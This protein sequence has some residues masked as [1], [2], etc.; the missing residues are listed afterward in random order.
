[1]ITGQRTG[2]HRGSEDQRRPQPS[3]G[4]RHR[5]LEVA[6]LGLNIE[7]QAEIFAF[8]FF[9][10]DNRITSEVSFPIPLPLPFLS[11]FLLF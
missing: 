1:M 2:K 4:G 8:C 10:I 7:S 5:L 3:L 11:F 9:L 6:V